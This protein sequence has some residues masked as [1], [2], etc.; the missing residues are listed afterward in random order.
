MIENA[1]VSGQRNLAPPPFLILAALVFWGW[2]SGM[3]VFGVIMGV[4]LESSRFIKIRFDFSPDDFRRL[5]HFCGVLGLAFVLYTFTMN[6]EG[7]GFGTLLHGSAAGRNAML[8]GI[9]AASAIP[10]WLPMLLFLLVA[11]F[12]L[13]RLGRRLCAGGHPRPLGHLRHRPIRTICAKL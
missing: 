12:H 10:R 2:L 5:W 4:V 7:G 1:P 3:L 9:H 8:S 11:A 13:P 6:D